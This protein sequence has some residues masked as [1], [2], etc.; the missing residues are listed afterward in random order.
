MASSQAAAAGYVGFGSFFVERSVEDMVSDDAYEP[1]PPPIQLFNDPLAAE[2]TELGATCRQLFLIDFENWT[3]INHGA[4]GGVC[5]P[6]F[7]EAAAWREHCERQP[8]V[9]LD[10]QLFPQ[11]VRVMR[12]LAS[13]MHARPQGIVMVPN[14]T[15]GLNVA[16]QSARLQPGDA[17]YMLNIG[18]GSVK[19]MAV[20]A[21]S[22]AEVVYGDVTFPI[23]GPD[24]ILKLVERTMPPHTKMAVFD[25][26]TSNTALVLPIQQLVQLC[27]S[28][29]ILVLIDAAH[30][31][32]QLVID[33][34]SLDADFYV[35]NCHKWLAGPRGSAVFWAHPRVKHTVRPLVVSHGS[36]HGFTS[37]FIWDGCRDYAPYLG[38]SAALRMW[39]QLGPHRC[40]TYMHDLVCQAATLL[41]SAW[42]TTTLAPLHMCA[43]MALVELP[44]KQAAA[45]GE[46][47]NP[48]EPP[49]N[50]TDAK[51][52]QE[53]LH[54]E[55]RIECPVKCIQ[56]RLY[57][58]ISAC[59][60]NTLHDYE[61]LREAILKIKI[62]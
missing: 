61:K 9:F 22:Q 49:A 55:F 50:S 46:L 27:R 47:Q 37:D 35:T 59:V 54:H 6:A 4:F 5:R 29:G 62:Y 30:A 25:A 1:P 39:R 23:S 18:Y 14:A 32:G 20:A 57:V 33:L 26:V 17:L 58:R 53:L 42:R 21:S 11:M 2:D 34:E 31:L 28:R 45:G 36:G 52:V 3:F 19:K 43:S 15:T 24:D 51:H 48:E 16:I 12:E 13:F 56:G 60:Y 41:A 38:V 8:L 10:R 40:R 44:F 7:A